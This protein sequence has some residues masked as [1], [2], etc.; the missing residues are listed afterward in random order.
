MV[1]FYLVKHSFVSESSMKTSRVCVGAEG[2]GRGGKGAN[3]AHPPP[4]GPAH[5]SQLVRASWPPSRGL[6]ANHSSRP[7]PKSQLAQELNL[8]GEKQGWEESGDPET[9]EG[10]G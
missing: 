6:P 3:C 7:P 9:G 1:F 10:R 8:L 5:S 4:P 2:A